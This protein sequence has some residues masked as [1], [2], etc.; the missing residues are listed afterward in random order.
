MSK[1]KRK[2]IVESQ[3]LELHQDK[4][5]AQKTLDY[6]EVFSAIQYIKENIKDSNIHKKSILKSIARIEQLIIEG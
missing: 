6:A 4:V 1:S 3:Q 5:L 2:T